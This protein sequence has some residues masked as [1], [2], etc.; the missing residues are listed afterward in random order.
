MKF[1]CLKQKIVLITGASRGIGSAIA[2]AFAIQG[3]KVILNYNKSKEQ[4]QSLADKL[5]SEGYS[6]DTMQADVSK[7]NEVE[8]MVDKIRCIG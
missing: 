2:K 1:T 5:I 3:A 8:A 4:A 6:I 7:N